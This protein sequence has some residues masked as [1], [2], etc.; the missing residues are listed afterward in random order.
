MQKTL[1]L[2]KKSLQLSEFGLLFN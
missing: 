2:P 1:L